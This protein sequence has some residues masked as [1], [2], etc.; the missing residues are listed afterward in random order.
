MRQ[1][2]SDLRQLFASTIIHVR[3]G[4][5]TSRTM[6]AQTLGISASTV[7]IYVDQLIATGHLDESGLEHGTMGRPKRR[8]QVRSS[9]GWF[10]GIEFN[11]DRIQMTGVDFSGQPLR[12]EEVRLPA[13][14][15]AA[16]IQDILLNNF[17]IWSQQQ[18]LRL[19]GI[20]VGAPGL[21]DTESGIALRY[22][23]VPDWNNVPLRDILHQKF[24]VPVTVENN[25]RAIALAERWF[26]GY[27]EEMDYVIVG[28]RSGFAI[29]CV[30]SGKLLHGAHSA[31]G[32]IGLWPWPLAGSDGI[33]QETHQVLSAAM[34]YRR[35]AGLSE[36]APVPEDLRTALL[37]LVNDVGTQWDEV[38]QDYARVLG[39]VKLLLDPK[40][41]LLHGP[42]TALGAS[43]CHAIN[44]A[45]THIAPALKELPLQL[46]CTQLGDDAGALGAAS[47][48]MES[49]MPG[50]L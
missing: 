18:S 42:L 4:R 12:T 26:G 45:A 28:P 9:P 3:S 24:G 13:H 36:T 6:L 40:I 10:A 2:T 32:E 14:P 16:A 39:C 8:L 31:A 30:Q 38:V 25:L 1:K 41:C 46:V 29:A 20:G 33:V 22:A 11:A 5:A 44:E 50:H 47:L 15:T 23:F 34:T 21:V 48:A 35:L 7:G 27:R 43:F 37:S 49:W 19:L 17:S